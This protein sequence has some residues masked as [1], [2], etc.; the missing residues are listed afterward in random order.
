MHR[1]IKG[2]L[3]STGVK[4]PLIKPHVSG[5]PLRG[6]KFFSLLGASAAVVGQE[7]TGR[8][9]QSRNRDGPL[10]PALP[11]AGRHLPAQGGCGSPEGP[12]GI[13]GAGLTAGRLQQG[14]SLEGDSIIW[15]LDSYINILFRGKKKNISP[16]K[17]A[18]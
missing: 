8:E 11:Q 1:N 16:S 17:S 9:S 7:E 6:M 18:F 12:V 15:Q 14:G 10:D 5:L 3:F 13:W 4:L 2:F